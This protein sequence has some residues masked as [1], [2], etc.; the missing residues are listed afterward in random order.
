MGLFNKFFGSSKSNKNPLDDK[1][2]IYGG[3]GTTEENAAV[4]NCA[5]MGTANQLINRFI[6]E[7]HGEFEKD[8]NRTIEHFLNSEK[9]TAPQ[10]RV[11]GVK[12]SDGTSHQYYFDVSRPMKVANKMLGFE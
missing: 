8:W 11:I 9:S 7:N 5:S 10:I 1:P 4:I 12:C 3:D 2:P 6:A